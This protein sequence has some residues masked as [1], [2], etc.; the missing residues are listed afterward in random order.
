ML[1]AFL[2]LLLV[3]RPALAQSA[4]E[5]RCH[6]EASECMKACTGDPKDAQKPEHSKRLVQCVNTCQQRTLEC[7]RACQPPPPR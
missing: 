3:A 4:C 6:R 1:R 5:T 2:L 7:K